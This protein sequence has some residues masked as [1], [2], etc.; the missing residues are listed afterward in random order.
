MPAPPLIGSARITGDSETLIKIL[1]HG[2]TGPVDGETYPDVMPPMGHNDDEYIAS[3][4]SY[5][6]SDFGEGPSVVRSRHVA[7]VRQETESRKGY[8][9]LPELTSDQ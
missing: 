7:Q 2:L 8:W 9:T 3:V 6:R 1:L 4:I 5:I